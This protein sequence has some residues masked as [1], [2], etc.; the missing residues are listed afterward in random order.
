MN[1]FLQLPVQ[2]RRL[3][4][5]QVDQTLG[6]QAF[7]VEKDFWACWT[8]REL[9]ALPGIGGHLTFKG[10]SRFRICA[11]RTRETPPNQAKSA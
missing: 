11:L 10:G 6:L 5:Q 2:R 8:L 4:F 9:F 1:D 3:A 7:S